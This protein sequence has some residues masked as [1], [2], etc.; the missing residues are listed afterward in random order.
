MEDVELVERHQ[1][2]VPEDGLLRGEVTRD[3]EVRAAPG[4]ARRILDDDGGDLPADAG[5]GRAPEELRRE[6]LATGLDG[7]EDAGRRGGG[8]VDAARRGDEAVPLPAEGGEGR[9][10]TEEDLG[11]G[12]RL[13]SA[14]GP[15]DR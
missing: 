2:E 5:R 3:V 7:V 8:E 6:A 12:L 1:V 15:W 4:E 11:R 13:R 9:V 14:T 10:E